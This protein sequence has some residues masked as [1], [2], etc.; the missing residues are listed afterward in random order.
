MLESNKS[1]NNM[2]QIILVSAEEHVGKM[3]QKRTK[4]PWITCEMIDKMAERRNWK[5]DKSENGKR[6]YRKVN[7]ELRK[8]S[9]QAK[10]DW[11]N[12]KCRE[13]E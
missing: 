13:I 4:K 2:K 6:P 3:K 9:D 7:N 11:I 8:I 10:E 5:N 1:W 12:S